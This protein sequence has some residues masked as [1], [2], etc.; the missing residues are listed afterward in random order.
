MGAEIL[1][2]HG[3][4]WTSTFRGFNVQAESHPGICIG[5]VRK[6]ACGL[7]IIMGLISHWLIALLCAQLALSMPPSLRKTGV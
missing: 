3:G 2:A 7:K 4:M 6:D 1:S 5:G